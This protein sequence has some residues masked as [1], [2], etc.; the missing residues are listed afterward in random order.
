LESFSKSQA[1]SI[2]SFL[3]RRPEFMETGKHVI[4]AVMLACEAPRQLHETDHPDHWYQYLFHGLAKDDWGSVDFS[5]LSIVTF[6][7][8]RSLEEY[9]LQSLMASYNKSREEACAKLL[10]LD[11]VH[12]YGALGSAE[13]WSSNYLEYGQGFELSRCLAAAASIQVIPEG[14]DNAPSVM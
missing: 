4:A 12:V 10:E 1:M 9:L 7:Y 5:N 2:D 14:R 6:N 11:I 13:P 3:A 8:D